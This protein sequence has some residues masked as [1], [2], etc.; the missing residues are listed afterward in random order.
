MF[1]PDPNINV[2]DPIERELHSFYTSLNRISVSLEDQ[3]GAETDGFVCVMFGADKTTVDVFVFLFQPESQIGTFYVREA[4]SLPANQGMKAGQGAVAFL[5]GMGFMVDFHDV[6]DLPSEEKVRLFSDYPPFVAD[7]QKFKD[8]LPE[9]DESILETS[10]TLQIEALLD[11]DSDQ[12]GSSQ[13]EEEEEEDNDPFTF[14]DEPSLP[15]PP[16]PP[17]EATEVDM[18]DMADFQVGLN[19]PEEVS[20]DFADLGQDTIVEALSSL[21][22]PESDDVDDSCNDDDGEIDLTEFGA[23]LDVE[24]TADMGESVIQ[25]DPEPFAPEPQAE[26]SAK[27]QEKSVNKEALIKLLSAY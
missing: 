7:R 27:P 1:S 20:A 13:P 16:P 2:L 6:S 10:S 12:T 26:V 18:S 23:E 5:E 17:V 8:V 21:E 15:P 25:H 9:T 3:P 22:A 24:M 11:E 19:P 4:G 14:M